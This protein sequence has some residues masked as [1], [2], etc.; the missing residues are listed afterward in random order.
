MTF[1]RCGIKVIAKAT[2]GALF[3][4]KRSDLGAVGTLGQ[5][6]NASRDILRAETEEER[7]SVRRRGRLAEVVGW[8][9]EV[10]ETR[11]RRRDELER[12][13]WWRRATCGGGDGEM[14]GDQRDEEAEEYRRHGAVGGAVVLGTVN[15]AAALMACPFK[16]VLVRITARWFL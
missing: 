13:D 8:A 15:G 12:R 16:E 14:R 1:Q 5:S 7:F 3:T 10:G 9:L 6:W 11:L 2:E 4:L